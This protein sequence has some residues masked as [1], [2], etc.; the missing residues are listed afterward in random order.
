MT[1]PLSGKLATVT[2]GSKGISTAIARN[3]ASKGANILPKSSTP[4][5][6]SL[7]L[8]LTKKYTKSA[9]TPGDAQPLRIN[10]PINNAGIGG[11]YVL[12]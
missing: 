9:A 2:G 11:N 6:T 8:S 12:G 1:K 7:C 3:L 10:I 5:A 4:L